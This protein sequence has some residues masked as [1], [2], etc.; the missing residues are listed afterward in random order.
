MHG[1]ELTSSAAGQRGQSSALLSL[2]ARTCEN[3][4]CAVLLEKGTSTERGQKARSCAS[5]CTHGFRHAHDLIVAV[6]SCLSSL[7]V[8]EHD[9]AYVFVY[10]HDTCNE[11]QRYTRRAFLD[12]DEGSRTDG[13]E[14]RHARTR[15]ADVLSRYSLLSS[16]ERP[17]FRPPLSSSFC[18]PWPRS[19]PSLTG[20]VLE[21]T[22][23]WRF[24]F[25]IIIGEKKLTNFIK[26]ILC[27]VSGQSKYIIV[28]KF[29]R[30]LDSV[31]KNLLYVSLIV[32]DQRS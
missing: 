20:S 10:H 11:G 13:S 3:T 27:S 7:P 23:I 26:I 19:H 6:S 29:L 8:C 25:A 31:F 5:A 9:D 21:E 24:W 28:S 4:P 16:L 30:F 14:R 32:S 1:N 15:P 17:F 18:T 12:D 22:V 2:L